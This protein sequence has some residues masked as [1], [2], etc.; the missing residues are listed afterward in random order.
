MVHGDPSETT[1]S[2]GARRRGGWAGLYAILAVAVLLCL[3]GYRVG[4]TPA[5][6]RVLQVGV[7][8][9]VLGLLVAWVRASLPSV[10]PQ[11]DRLTITAQPF[12][13][14]RVPLRGRQPDGGRVAVPL[15]AR[16]RARVLRLAARRRPGQAP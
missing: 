2:T 10:L 4:T 8:L 9:V 14:I 7:T 15:R 11:E 1:T 13:V 5:L 6:A 3:M 16:R 12:S